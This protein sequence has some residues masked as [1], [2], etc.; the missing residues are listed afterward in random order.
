M[1]EI[2]CVGDKFE[3]LMT[4]LSTSPTI[5]VTNKNIVAIDE[6]QNCSSWTRPEE[7][8]LRSAK[9]DF[10]DLNLFWLEPNL[11]WLK[12][13]VQFYEIRLYL[14]SRIITKFLTR[15]TRVIDYVVKTV[16]KLW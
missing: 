15:V 14:T 12:A 5:F 8:Q 9:I 4:H 10:W 7:K 13:K 3:T 2:E 11:L 6:S 1:L 16:V